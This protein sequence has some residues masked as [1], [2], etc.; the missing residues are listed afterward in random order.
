MVDG[1]DDVARPI[2]RQCQMHGTKRLTSSQSPVNSASSTCN[3]TSVTAGPGGPPTQSKAGLLGAVG[4]A[5][6]GGWTAGMLP[7]TDLCWAPVFLGC[8]IASISP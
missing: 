7:Q 3:L 4:W 5:G 8:H 6:L 1:R 2:M